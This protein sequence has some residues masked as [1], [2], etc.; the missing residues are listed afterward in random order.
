MFFSVATI[1]A[2]LPEGAGN[3]LSLI[4]GRGVELSGRFPFAVPREW[5]CMKKGM[6]P[7]KRRA[8]RVTEATFTK[9]RSAGA[10]D[11][12]R[13]YAEW[14]ARMPES[15]RREAPLPEAEMRQCLQCALRVL[16]DPSLQALSQVGGCTRAIVAS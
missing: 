12:E 10:V 8:W 9:R 11:L 2:A 13:I 5:E 7:G 1:D 3:S 15:L 16:E 14:L 6:F 4:V